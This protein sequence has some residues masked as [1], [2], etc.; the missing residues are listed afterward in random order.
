MS[1]DRTF[2]RHPVKETRSMVVV[3][4]DPHK[5]SHTAVAVDHNGQRLAQITVGNSVPELIR[6]LDWTRRLVAPVG[7]RGLSRL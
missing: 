7:G 4:I 6:L 1:A 5:H 3:G 2:I